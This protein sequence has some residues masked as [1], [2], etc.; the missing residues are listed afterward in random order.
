MIRQTGA[1]SEFNIVPAHLIL[2]FTFRRFYHLF[3][4]ISLIKFNDLG[5]L[6]NEFVDI[7]VNLDQEF[8]DVAGKL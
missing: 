7:R 2:A 6:R 3:R 8:V 1:L 5:V 4:L